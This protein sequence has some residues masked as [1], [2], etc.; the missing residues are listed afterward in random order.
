MTKA[1]DEACIGNRYLV[2]GVFLL[3]KISIFFFFFFAAEQVSLPTTGSPPNVRFGGNGRAVH[4][5]RNKQNKKRGNI[6][7]TIGDTGGYNSVR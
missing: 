7:G 5:R 2:R 6:F 1:I 4:G 3:G